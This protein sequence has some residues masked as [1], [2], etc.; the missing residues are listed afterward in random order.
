MRVGSL[1]TKCT[2]LSLLQ[3]KLDLDQRVEEVLLREPLSSPNHIRDCELAAQTLQTALKDVSEFP[4]GVE[5]LQAV[6]EQ[7]ENF[8]ELSASFGR[9]LFAHVSGLFTLNVSQYVCL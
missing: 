2:S 7:K 3:A 8:K 4:S 6:T 1:V 5:I 9:R